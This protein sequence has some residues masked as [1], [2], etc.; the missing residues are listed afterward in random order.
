MN[1]L[2][3]T[4]I[5]LVVL[6]LAIVACGSTEATS[7]PNVTL[8][9]VAPNQ[10]TTTVPSQATAQ[11][12]TDTNDVPHSLADVVPGEVYTFKVD[13]TQTTVEYAVD[14][15]LFGNKQVTRGSTNAVEG[16]FQL[17]LVD[18]QPIVEMSN[19]QVDLRT[20]TSD[21]SVRDAAIRMQWLE[22]N[23]YPM[24]VF[25]AKEI[26][27]LPMDAVQGQ[28]YTF[29]VSGDMTI[30]DITKPVTF[31]V[32]VTVNGAMLTGEGTTQIYMKDFGFNPPEILGRFTVSDPA[33][34]TVKGVANLVEG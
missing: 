32:T 28:A 31:D 7:T 19:L 23:E 33:T 13:P 6:A 26:E 22:S 20:L 8:A 1:K 9:T 15:V 29:K 17:K 4:S 21:N 11:N 12:T 30:R 5:I 3:Q 10:V 27:G 18:G 24:A 14:E 2:I 16:E 25:V 34:I